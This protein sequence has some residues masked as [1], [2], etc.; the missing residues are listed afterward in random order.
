[1]LRRRFPVWENHAWRGG[2]R[3][4]FQRPL[5]WPQAGLSARSRSAQPPQRLRKPPLTRLTIQV[6]G[7]WTPVA[8]AWARATLDL[9]C[10]PRTCPAAAKGGD[11]SK[12]AANA[13]GNGWD[14][15]AATP[16]RRRCSE[17]AAHAQSAGDPP[18]CGLQYDPARPETYATH[19]GVRGGNL[20]PGSPRCSSARHLRRLQA[21][22]RWMVTVHCGAGLLWGHSATPAA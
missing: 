14:G 12:A 1:M 11:V 19:R 9:A 4:H 13:A 7:R 8:P 18:S 5:A 17:K 6:R 15:S 22:E 21:A 2:E 16:Y 3:L 20:A 10:L